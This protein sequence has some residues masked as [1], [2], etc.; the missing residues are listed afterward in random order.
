MK[1][2][3]RAT[4]SDMSVRE[5]YVATDIEGDGPIPGL[6]SLLSVGMAVVGWERS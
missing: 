3:D 2:N 6:Y 4:S 5:L 1:A